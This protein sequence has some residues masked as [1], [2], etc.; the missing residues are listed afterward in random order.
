MNKG[1]FSFALNGEYFG[2]AFTN[3][4]L[5]KGPIVVAVSLLHRAGCSI[6][7]SKPIPAYFP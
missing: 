7:S 4:A 1:Q 2:V 3:A 5:T 6:D